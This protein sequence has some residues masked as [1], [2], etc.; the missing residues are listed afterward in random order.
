M[1]KILL[2]I[3]GRIG[4]ALAEKILRELLADLEA[5]LNLPSAGPLDPGTA[6]LLDAHKR[7]TRTP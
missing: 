7:A 1:E 2:T 5:K 3:L 6:A 4:P